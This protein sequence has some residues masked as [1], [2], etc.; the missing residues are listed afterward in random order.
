MLT[1]SSICKGNSH[2]TAI[3][4]VILEY[5]LCLLKLCRIQIPDAKFHV[6]H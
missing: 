4:Q 2:L 3:I 1:L 6:W 5:S